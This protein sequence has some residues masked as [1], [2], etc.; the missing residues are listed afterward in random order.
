MLQEDEIKTK[1]VISQEIK[2]IDQEDLVLEPHNIKEQ[3]AVPRPEDQAT[4]I[5]QGLHQAEVGAMELC[6]LEEEL[7]EVLLQEEDLEVRLNLEEEK[8]EALG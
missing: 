3:E 7:L 1:E 4:G 8:L 5:N 6:Q 2:T